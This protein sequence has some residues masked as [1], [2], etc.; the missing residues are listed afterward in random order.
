VKEPETTKITREQASVLLKADLAN[1]ARKVKEGKTLSAGER[2]LL[3]NA[4]SGEP[5]ASTAT[6]AKN[7]VEM[8]AILKLNRK[9]IQRELKMEGC[10][11]RRPDGRYDVQAWK[12]WRENRR[13]IDTAEGMTQS[14][15]RARQILLQNQKIEFQLAQL[16]GEFIPVVDVEKWVSDMVLAAKRILYS[17]PPSLAPQVVGVSVPEAER[18]IRESI[19]E[20]LEQ[21]H[22]A[23]WNDRK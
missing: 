20:S 17:M 8:A 12:A 2:N 4:L 9:T 10:P 6:F 15:L 14:E 22:A 18:R 7:M 1:L 11:G 21:L 5:E 23:P 19:D 16:R 3:K 13:G